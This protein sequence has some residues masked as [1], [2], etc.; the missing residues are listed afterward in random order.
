MHMQLFHFLAHLSRKLIGELIVYHCPVVCLRRCRRPQ[1]SNISGTTKPI[2]DKLYVEY[3][4]GGG[5]KVGVNGPGHLTKMAAVPIKGKSK[6]R[7]RTGNGAIRNTFQFQ[8][9]RWK[10][11]NK[12][13]G[14][15]TRKTYCKPNVQPF[16]Q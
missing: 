6:R 10:K 5:I 11:L 16:S 7:Q 12:Q 9:S 2:K 13:P 3:P 14:T 8:K 4:L 15:Y 1:C